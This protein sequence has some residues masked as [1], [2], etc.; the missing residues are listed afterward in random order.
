MSPDMLLTDSFTSLP[1]PWARRS[2]WRWGGGIN[3]VSVSLIT[4]QIIVFHKGLLS[5]CFIIWIRT[6]MI[7][8]RCSQFFCSCQRGGVDNQGEILG[9]ARTTGHNWC[10]IL[11]GPL[12]AA[13]TTPPRLG[14][15]FLSAGRPA[16]PGKAARLPVFLSPWDIAYSKLS[17]WKGKRSSEHK[18]NNCCEFKQTACSE[19]I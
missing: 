16:S 13:L 18:K 4:T 7:S 10:E 2:G 6:T 14:P 15:S 5:N 17:C 11:S 3:P 8:G 19:S 1:K 12:W 9:R